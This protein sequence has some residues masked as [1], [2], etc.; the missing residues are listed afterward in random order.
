MK[1]GAVVRGDFFRVLNLAP[2][3]GRD[4]R[5]DEDGVAGRD[6]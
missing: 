5:P 1:C 2:V 3:A 4:F 6:A